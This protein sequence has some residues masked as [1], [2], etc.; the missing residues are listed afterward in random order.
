MKISKRSWICDPSRSREIENSP[1]GLE[2]AW[3]FSYC[4]SVV[5][6]CVDIVIRKV[7][8]GCFPRIEIAK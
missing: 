5:Q 3:R 6:G 2:V 1:R 8:D 4:L 7:H